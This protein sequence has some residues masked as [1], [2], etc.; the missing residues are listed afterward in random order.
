MEKDFKVSPTSKEEKKLLPKIKIDGIEPEF[1]S[2][3]NKEEIHATLLTEI[4]NKNAYLNALVDE[5]EIMSIVY[6]EKKEGVVV[7]KISPKI[8]AAMKLRR[9]SLY[10]GLQSYHIKD[11]VHIIQCFHCQKFG[12][13]VGSKYCQ[14]KNE[15]PTCFYCAGQHK[16]IDCKIKKE[17]RNHKCS[18]CLRSGNKYLIDRASSHNATHELCP[19]VIRETEAVM[20]RT[21]E[22]EEAKNEY[23]QKIRRLQ[24]RLKGY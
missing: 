8:R 4:K 6:A 22:Y 5:D 12:H 13:K 14:L 7:I 1:L 2:G 11:Q 16:S 9:D 19:F 18:N 17:K 23:K 21:L 3:D 20:S 15:K 24:Q 10:I